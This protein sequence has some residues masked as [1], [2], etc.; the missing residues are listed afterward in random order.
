MSSAARLF[1]SIVMTDVEESVAKAK[2]VIGEIRRRVRIYKIMCVV[3]FISSTF[4][5]F[6]LHTMTCMITIYMY[7]VHN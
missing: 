6:S 2:Q 7:N 4:S 1:W 5:P 3:F